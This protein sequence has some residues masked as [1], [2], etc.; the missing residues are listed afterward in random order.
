MISKATVSKK[1]YKTGGL[2]SS[3]SIKE[4]KKKLNKEFGG[5]GVVFGF[6]CVFF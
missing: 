6:G 3:F 4:K 5:R 1:L 2:C